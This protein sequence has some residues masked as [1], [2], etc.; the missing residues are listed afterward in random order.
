[1]AF[2]AEQFRKDAADAGYSP[3]EIEAAV[4][5]QS[6]KNTTGPANLGPAE[7]SG[8]LASV[9]SQLPQGAQTFAEDSKNMLYGAGA[10]TAL[11]GAYGLYK[12]YQAH[13]DRALDREMK[14]LQIL[15]MK[16]RLGQVPPP[17]APAA[18]A[19]VAPTGQPGLTITRGTGSPAEMATFENLFQRATGQAPAPAET[20]P[21]ADRLAQLE[22][23]ARQGRAAGLGTPTAPAP[24]AAAPS[25]M[26][27]PAL[28][29][30]LIPNPNATGFHD[31]YLPGPA[32]TTPSSATVAANPAATGTDMA[33]AVGREQLATPAPEAEATTP[34]AT[35]G[36]PAGSKSL[37]PEQRTMKEVGER[38]AGARNWLLNTLGNDP[39]AYE[40]FIK[41]YRGGTEYPTVQEAYRAIEDNLGGPLRSEFMK[42]QKGERAG[43]E[44][45][46]MG[47]LQPKVPPT[48][49]A[50]PGAALPPQAKKQGGFVLGAMPTELTPA[51]RVAAN[52]GRQLTGDLKMGAAALPFS[53]ATDVRQQNV[54]YE[55][56][57]QKELA[58]SKDPV[59]IAELQNEMQKLEEQRYLKA[60]YNRVVKQ[61]VPAIARPAFQP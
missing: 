31:A 38:A 21:A 57:L 9:M 8:M 24:S 6:G 34:A 42:A 60:M 2:N 40:A 45:A 19:P 22:E 33:N 55:R 7:N 36:R 25:S 50:T 11:G 1:M 43:T 52:F 58:S 46:F 13:Q 41:Q 20:T 14:Q 5:K 29:P 39:V 37:T 16:Q 15:E 23:R 28:P 53:V 51:G 4:A 56:E 27:F 54:G 18:A 12:A 17:A 48:Q 35:K 10:L 26:N 30:D 47:P 44:R 59:R 49:E 3:E 61:N 32:A